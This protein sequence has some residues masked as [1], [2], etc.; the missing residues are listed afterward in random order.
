MITKENYFKEVKS[1]DYKSLSEALKESFD[2]IR[3]GSKDYTT[4]QYLDD[5]KEFL[6]MYFGKL[7][8]FLESKAQ[9][10]KGKEKNSATKAQVVKKKKKVVKKESNTRVANKPDK[11]S[12][13]SK[14]VEKLDEEIRFIKR[15]VLLNGKVKTK[16][17]VLLFLNALQKS[18]TE[19]RIRK[20]SKY[21][22]EIIHIQDKLVELYNKMLE[23]VEVKLSE[24]DY[25][26]LKSIA[27]SQKSMLSITYIKRYISLHGKKDVKEKAKR[28]LTLLEKSVKKGNLSKDDPYKDR[29]NNIY[30]A[31]KS[32]LDNKTK[33]PSIEQAE[34]NGL[35]G[36]LEQHNPNSKKK[37]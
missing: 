6:D 8:K 7:N 27:Y 9:R 29:L 15:Y 30:V 35:M 14:P 34:L 31:L 25:E 2:T 28:L 20:T 19:K 11:K 18:I 24:K 13:E 12:P 4:W 5:D 32:Y 3:F 21:A 33:T 16:S 37:V 22:K 23:Q 36:I 1:I 26:H 17:Q 10:V